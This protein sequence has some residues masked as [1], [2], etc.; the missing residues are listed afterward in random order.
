M[1][2]N[3]YASVAKSNL[4]LEE[5]NLILR[6]L[7]FLMYVGHLFKDDHQKHKDCASKI[8][9]LLQSNLDNG[10]VLLELK[11][12]GEDYSL[13]D[14]DVVAAWNAA[15]SSKMDE[16]SN[17]PNSKDMKQILDL[18][19]VVDRD[20]LKKRFPEPFLRVLERACTDSVWTCPSC[21][22]ENEPEALHCEACERKRPETKKDSGCKKIWGCT[23]C[24]FHNDDDEEFKRTHCSL[25]Y[26]PK[27]DKV[28]D[29]LPAMDEALIM[30]KLGQLA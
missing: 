29:P 5:Q 28:Q 10:A 1:Y 7:Y 11:N 2:R 24:S 14:S 3:V 20:D 13:K 16:Q 22:L 25:C 19:N 8:Y 15:K 21:T 30:E 23:N 17:L 18:F 9:S 4:A 12:I 6:C 27:P 26:Y